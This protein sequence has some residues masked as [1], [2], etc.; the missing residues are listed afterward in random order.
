[1]LVGQ[2]CRT[3]VFRHLWDAWACC[4]TRIDK[5]VSRVAAPIPPPAA[6]GHF[7]AAR[8]AI[9]SVLP[10][11]GNQRGSR[12]QGGVGDQAAD[13]ISKG[14]DPDGSAFHLIVRADFRAE[15]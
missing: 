1:M 5:E 9:Y 3:L 15:Q 2:A 7:D 14:R 10:L 12:T 4:I 6:G 8:P 13:G 11:P